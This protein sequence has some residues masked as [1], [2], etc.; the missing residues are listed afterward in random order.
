MG[1][2]VAALALDHDH[3]RVG[4][5]STPFVFAFD[6]LPVI[7]ILAGLPIICVRSGRTKPQPEVSAEGVEAAVQPAGGD[8]RHTLRVETSL[9]VMDEREGV[10]FGASTDMQSGNGFAHQ[11]EDKPAPCGANGLANA[12]IQLVHL[13]EG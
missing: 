1:K 5:C 10:V 7:E 4:E 12:G 8:R 2:E 6:E 13:N 9:E 3:V 11:V